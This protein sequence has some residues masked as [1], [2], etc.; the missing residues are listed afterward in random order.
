MAG[1]SRFKPF[2]KPPPA[3]CNLGQI[4]LP[5]P[6]MLVHQRQPRAR[7]RH[8]ERRAFCA[9]GKAQHPRQIAMQGICRSP[10]SGV[11]PI[12]SLATG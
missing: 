5:Q 9:R 12:C 11:R 8:E 10:F 7:P 3:G 4:P 1:S 6:P 2:N